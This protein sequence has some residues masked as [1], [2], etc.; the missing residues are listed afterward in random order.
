MDREQFTKLQGKRIKAA[1]IIAGLDQIEMA[2]K[3]N[4]H[5]GSLSRYENG[6]RSVPAYCLY[7]IAK[8]TNQ[9]INFFFPEQG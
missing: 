5:H 7:Q 2:K 1:R 3:A 6:T 8:V 4:I 9:P